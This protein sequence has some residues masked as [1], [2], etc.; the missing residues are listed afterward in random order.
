MPRRVRSR[1]IRRT[2]VANARTERDFTLWGED[3]GDN[4]NLQDVVTD[5]IIFAPGQTTQ[6]MGFTI[7]G[8]NRF[9]GTRALVWTIDEDANFGFSQ[10]IYVFNEAIAGDPIF[11]PGSPDEPSEWFIDS[12]PQ[13]I[14]LQLNSSIRT[15]T[16]IIED[17]ELPERILRG[18]ENGDTIQVPNNDFVN[19]QNR[20]PASLYGYA[21]Y[22]YGGNDLI[23]GADGI[24]DLF[25]WDG[26]DTLHG[27]NSS[28]YLAGNRGNDQLYG[29]PEAAPNS[30]A[31]GS[32]LLDGGDGNDSLFG[33]PGTD[34]LFGSVGNDTLRGGNTTESGAD[35]LSG[36]EGSDVLYGGGGQDT[37]EGGTGTDRFEFYDPLN[38]GDDFIIDFN[39]SNENLYIYLGNATNSS[40]IYRNSGLIFQPNLTL[41]ADQFVSFDQ[42]QEVNVQARDV[43]DRFLYNRRSATL[44]FDR[45]GTGSAARQRIAVLRDPTVPLNPA[46][47]PELSATN[48]IRFGGMEGNRIIADPAGSSIN[49]TGRD[50]WLIGR[51][52][53]DRLNGSVGNDI[54]NGGSGNDTL[55]GGSGDDILYGGTNEDRG[56]GGAGRDLFVLQTGPGILTIVDFEQF[57]DQLGGVQGISVNNLVFEDQGSGTLI[58]LGTDSLALV[59]GI[60][61]NQIRRGAIVPVPPPPV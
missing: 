42:A 41:S 6:N 58:R 19:A 28:D 33:G 43:N 29:E 16:I 57:Q 23:Q 56:Q 27:Q 13:N 35:L 8:D 21:V 45:D 18:T 44:Y 20:L 30:L 59:Q 34:T 25:G 5:E 22:G 53:A 31:A 36:E 10:D 37:L 17:D 52:G 54:L 49:G 47:H 2:A 11:Q 26:D 61:P 32:D 40:R 3:W 38:D 15:V 24:D 48:F 7:R 4:W 55:I 46:S 51:E 9:D 12:A 50:D 60:L 1:R 39:P 14:P